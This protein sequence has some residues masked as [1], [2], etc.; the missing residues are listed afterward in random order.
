MGWISSTIPV[1]G[2]TFLTP[3]PYSRLGVLLP[4][5]KIPSVFLLRH[6]SYSLWLVVGCIPLSNTV[7]ILLCVEMLST[8]Q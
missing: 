5:D 1:V 4:R 7:R 8:Y 3:L 6:I 2:I